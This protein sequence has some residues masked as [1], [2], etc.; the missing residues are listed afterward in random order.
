MS[1]CVCECVNVRLGRCNYELA[2]GVTERIS[3]VCKQNRE[4]ERETQREREREGEREGGR[5]R[6]TE[7][8]RKR[9]RPKS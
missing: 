4:R 9:E 7:L 6:T 8:E 2:R 3:S 5:G 1:V